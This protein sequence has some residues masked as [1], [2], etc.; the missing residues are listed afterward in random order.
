MAIGDY[1]LDLNVLYQLGF[2]KGIH[3]EN[4]YLNEFLNPFISLGKKKTNAV[5]SLLQRALQDP[6]SL[7]KT[8]FT[9]VS[10]LQS[11]VTMHLPIQI[12]DYTDF[13]SSKHHA[14]NVGKLY[15]GGT[16]L[17]PN[18]EHMPIAYHGRASSIVVSGTPIKRP[19]GQF[20]EKGK[21]DPVFGYTSFL[22]FELELATV[23][24]KESELGDAV[25]CDQAHDYIFGFA[26]FNDWSARDFQKWEYQPLGPFL[27]KNFASTLSPWI[28]TTEA[29]EPFKK[30]VKP[31]KK[32]L[33][34]L[35]AEFLYTY[36]ISLS[37]K[38]NN[39]LIVATNFKHLH[40]TPCQ[41]IAHHTVNGCNLRIGDVLASGTIS[42]PE[43]HGKGCLLEITKAG[44]VPLILE[45]ESKR[46][47]V[48]DGDVVVM[49]AFCS[50]ENKS[51]GFG[52]NLGQIKKDTMSRKKSE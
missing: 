9:D 23:I 44:A 16:G 12:G 7:L 40:W 28:I 13:Y 24:G 32:Q 11:E 3:S 22:D 29:L 20:L 35:Q 25:S 41:Q 19:K 48:L 43:Q 21:N 4:V 46:F 38:L 14:E 2:F 39:Q 36:D 8:K 18:W 47:S 15:R 50:N 49:N 37:V 51:I 31:E 34:Y 10:Y 6:N 17:T 52:E 1:V 26:L 42:G 33:E 30:K 45:D 5:R 27:G